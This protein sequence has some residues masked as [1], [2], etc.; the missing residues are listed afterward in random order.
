MSTQALTE[1]VY[2]IL[3]VLLEPKHGYGIMQEV[4]ELSKGRIKWQLGPSM[5]R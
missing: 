2:Y 5:G 1:A 4:E 3:L